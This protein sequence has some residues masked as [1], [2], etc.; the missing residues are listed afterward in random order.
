MMTR[1]QRRPFSRQ[2]LALPSRRHVALVDMDKALFA[3]RSPQC[4]FD[5]RGNEQG[6][7]LMR[8]APSR[9]ERAGVKSDCLCIDQM[10]RERQIAMNLNGKVLEMDRPRAPPA[11][12]ASKAAHTWNCTQ[13]SRQYSPQEAP[14]GGGIHD[15]RQAT[16][17]PQLGPYPSNLHSHNY[18][19]KHFKFQRALSSSP[20]P[21]V[22]QFGA[23][24][25]ALRPRQS[26]RVGH[27]KHRQNFPGI[28]VSSRT[29]DKTTICES[30]LAGSMLQAPVA[31]TGQDIPS[32][33]RRVRAESL[34]SPNGAG[35]RAIRLTMTL[36]RIPCL[37]FYTRKHHRV[38]V[39]R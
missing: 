27:E 3:V 29:G 34:S 24:P 4:R 32:G 39:R 15:S 22:R 30:L 7:V 33:H 8:M 21:T 1:L 12:P 35:A 28:T 10:N 23:E 5:G 16:R 6:G 13:T 38:F 26:R 20:Y 25:E 11:C 36:A 9:R 18:K 14:R 31:S 17:N 37:L 19:L 2:K